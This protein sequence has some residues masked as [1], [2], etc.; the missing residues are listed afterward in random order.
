MTTNY[1]E[2]EG[3]KKKY[4]APLVVIMLCAV[5]L[6][7]AA[8][9]A[10]YYTTVTGNGNLDGDYVV[11]DLYDDGSGTAFTKF[12]V[13]GNAII[14][15]ETDKTKSPAAYV[16]KVDS[17]TIEFTTHIMINVSDDLKDKTFTLSQLGDG[18][19]SYTNESTAGKLT[20]SDAKITNLVKDSSDSTSDELDLT[21]VAGAY[22]TV[23]ISCM[24]AGD[25][26][27]TFGSYTTFEDLTADVGKISNGTVSI[28]FSASE[29]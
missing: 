3:T 20:L 14:Y 5:A 21:M 16:A 13:N 26:T 25:E 24:V 4:L 9:A 7:G 17:K 15:S 28:K 6:T 8:Y 23:T 10:T 29:N 2:N 27:E 22:Y 19:F 18:D 11:I 12:K 1:M